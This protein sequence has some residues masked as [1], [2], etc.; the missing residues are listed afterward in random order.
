[1]TTKHP[2]TARKGVTFNLE[3]NTTLEYTPYKAK[4]RKPGKE[5]K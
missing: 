4:N 3:N 5:E 2:E 1:M